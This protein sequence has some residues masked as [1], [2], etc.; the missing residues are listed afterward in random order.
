[1]KKYFALAL[2]FY[3]SESR[4]QDKKTDSLLQLITREANV[5]NKS[6]LLN[7][8]SFHLRTK[9]FQ[10]SLSYANQAFDLAKQAND[11]SEQG[12]ARL[13]MGIEFYYMGIYDEAIANY[14]AA[15]KIYEQIH[16]KEG[17][18]SVLNEL[19]TFHNK[20]GDLEKAQK[21]FEQALA[22]AQETKD[23]SLI[24]NSLN[25]LGIVYE[26]RKDFKAAMEYYKNSAVIKE[27]LNDLNGVSYNYD[28][29][30]TLQAQLGN[31]KEAADYLNRVITIR[32]KINDRAGYAIALNNL[33]EMY[34]MKKDFIAAKKYFNMA[35]KLTYEINYKDLR[36]YIFSLLSDISKTEGD[37]QKSYLY[38]AQSYQ[39]KD[40]LLNEQKSK[41][42]LELQTKYETEKKENQIVLLTQQNEIK[43]IHIR[44]N[45]LAIAG[46]VI[47]ISGLIAFGRLW[48][49]RTRLKQQAE[50]ESARAEL[51]QEQ[52]QAVIAS[53]EEERKRFAADLHDGLGQIISALRLGLSKEKVESSTITY[54]LSLLNDMN[55]EI[56]NIAFN[57][58]PQVLMK[59]G[60]HEALKE[61]AQRIS[62]SGKV[63]IEV[64]TYNLHPAMDSV[65]RIALY[66]ICQEWINNAMKYSGCTKI[67]VQAVQHP[68]ELVLTLEDDG[69]GFDQNLLMHSK[70]NGWKN[71]NSRL[72]LIHG[73][74]EI[75]SVIGRKGTVAILTV[76]V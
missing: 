42:I 18:S 62:Q 59:E 63:T 8:L 66:R 35:L 67:M 3:F 54:S 45:T 37:H 76:P 36:G 75:D 56:R 17:M 30:G 6:V 16:D 57:L 44:Q 10:K 38:L 73:T 48:Q 20:Q 11:F 46:L 55:V 69:N 14:L 72:S 31:F 71:I 58:M 21:S 22:L 50:L 25:N 15:L 51:R 49:T 74:I 24:G 60:L 34:L 41:Q 26:K 39:V 29:M 12:R 5:R 23:S 68:D 65:H 9:D 43:D 4:A 27:A 40:S 53:Q 64:Q 32:K 52:L 28:N 19:G 33:G 70:G 7:Q 13:Y 1:M 2:L 47:F 61:L